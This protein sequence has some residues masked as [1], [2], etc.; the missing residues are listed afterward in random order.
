MLALVKLKPVQAEDRE[1]TAPNIGTVN[2]SKKLLL[3]ENVLRWV[4][5]MLLRW[6][7][8]EEQAL[9]GETVE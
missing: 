8:P 2:T 5:L 4:V 7:K 1:R 9:P 6:E 3:F